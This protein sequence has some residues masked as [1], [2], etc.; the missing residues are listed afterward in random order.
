VF[1]RFYRVLGAKAEGSGLGLAIVKE[2]AQRHRADVCVSEISGDESHATGARFELSF[3]VNS[4]R[5]D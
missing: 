4:N 1:D 3:V 2:I 5:N